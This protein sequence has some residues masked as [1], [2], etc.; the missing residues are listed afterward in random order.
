MFEDKA[1]IVQQVYTEPVPVVNENY[2]T[3]ILTIVPMV[4]ACSTESGSWPDLI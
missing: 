3:H 1:N 4:K 2:M